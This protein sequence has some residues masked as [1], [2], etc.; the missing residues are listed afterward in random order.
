[1]GAASPLRSL[2]GASAVQIGTAYLLCPEALTSPVH[3]RALA[4]GSVDDT[5]LTNVFTGR[6]A[7]GR[8]NRLID[9]LGPMSADAPAF[10]TASAAVAPLRAAAEGKG[11]GDFSPLWSGQAGV[12]TSDIPASDL[13]RDLMASRAS[14]ARHERA[15]MTRVAV[16]GGSGFIAAWC[17]AQL[18]EE[19]H[20]VVATIRSPQREADVRA[21]VG[22]TSTS[23]LSFGVADLSRDDGWD[24]ALAG[25]EVVLHVASPMSSDEVEADRMIADAVDGTLRV[26]AAADRAGARRVVMTSS[27]AAA[28]PDGSQLSGTVDET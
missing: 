15:A 17:I 13:T 28:T 6:P 14:I 24:D 10:P 1:M 21:A 3:R 7:R 12:M 8:R 18:L 5:V 19:G 9:E 22:T 20:E 23:P 11:S 16:T 4:G 27:C 2:L 25:C 26:L